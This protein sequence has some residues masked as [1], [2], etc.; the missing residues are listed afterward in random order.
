MALVWYAARAGVHGPALVV[1]YLAG[2]LVWTLFE[3][4][5]HRFSFHRAP[6]TRLEVA[7][8]YL[9]HGVHHAYPDDSRRWMMPL[10]VTLPISAAIIFAARARWAASRRC[11]LWR[12]SCT[13]ISCTIRC[14][15][16]FIEG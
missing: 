10:I 11:P 6:A 9:M 8:A 7:L 1:A 14:I 12:A 5:M 4:V 13:A 2:L 16:R 3:Y 15:T